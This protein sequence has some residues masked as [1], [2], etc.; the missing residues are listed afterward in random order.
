MI[1]Q[2]ALV[3]KIGDS[4]FPTEREGGFKELAALQVDQDRCVGDEDAHEG[5]G[6]GACS[7]AAL[8]CPTLSRSNS[9]ALVS[10]TTPS[11]SAL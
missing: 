5:Q 4:E 11:A 9:A 6:V 1:A 7:I 2:L 3:E 10:D 8:S